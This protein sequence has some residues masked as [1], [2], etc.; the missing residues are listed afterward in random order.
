[1]CIRA[2]ETDPWQLEDVPDNFKTQ[3]KCDAVVSRDSYLLQCASGWLL[4][5]IHVIDVHVIDEKR[6]KIQQ[7]SQIH[8]N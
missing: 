6:C 1:M 2:A 5:Q 8:D 3:E 7:L 4:R